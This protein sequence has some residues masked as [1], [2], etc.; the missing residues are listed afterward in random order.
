M[1]Q[2]LNTKNSNINILVNDKQEV[3]IKF[4][5]NYAEKSNADIPTYTTFIGLF[6]LLGNL[7]HLDNLFLI[8]ALKKSD[9]FSPL[10]NAPLS[11][12]F[13]TFVLSLGMIP[14]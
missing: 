1:L 11:Q 9:I 6:Y 5:N 7:E 13:L 2:V 14:S 12:K 3:V 4:K 10:D 8:L